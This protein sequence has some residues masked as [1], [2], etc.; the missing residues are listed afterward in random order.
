MKVHRMQ[1][2]GVAIGSDGR[3]RYRGIIRVCKAV[4]EPARANYDELKADCYDW[5]QLAKC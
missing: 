1:A 2:P 5:N 4:V 3:C